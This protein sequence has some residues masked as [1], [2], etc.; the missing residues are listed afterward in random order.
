M[1]LDVQEERVAAWTCV[2][3]ISRESEVMTWWKMGRI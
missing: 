1:L 2:G 3:S